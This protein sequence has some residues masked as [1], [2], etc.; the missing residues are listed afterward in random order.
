MNKDFVYIYYCSKN[1]SEAT[2][3]CIFLE[4]KGI[5]CW[6]SPR[7]VLSSLDYTTQ[8][9]AAINDSALSILVATN[10][11]NNI[12]TLPNELNIIAT[13]KKTLISFKIEN[14]DISNALIYYYKEVKPINAYENFDS[15]LNSLY[16]ELSLLLNNINNN[17]TEEV[18]EAT[19]INEEDTSNT[20]NNNKEQND[21]KKQN[22]QQNNNNSEYKY[23][24]KCG[25]KMPSSFSICT[26][27][28]KFFEKE[29]TNTTNQTKY[30][31]T[32]TKPNKHVYQIIIFIF[33]IISTI[34]LATFIIPL[35][36]CIPMTITYWNKIR[37]NEKVSITFKICSL[38]FMGIIPGLLMLFEDEIK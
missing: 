36:W 31:F 28:G 32:S 23:C 34:Y 9:T 20:I 15:G 29:N 38:I 5:N 24:T 37:K 35:F 11:T 14:F 8:V 6:M 27:C 33:M 4:S 19:F 12:D 26:N 16:N 21:N 10:E 1:Y 22:Q 17:E 18:F 30:D 2:K 7:N 25:A 13:K 3:I